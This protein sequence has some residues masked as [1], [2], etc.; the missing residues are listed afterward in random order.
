MACDCSQDHLETSGSGVVWLGRR[1]LLYFFCMDPSSYLPILHHLL[2]L[3]GLPVFESVFLKFVM[4]F[5][6]ETTLRH[7]SRDEGCKNQGPLA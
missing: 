6:S 4:E 2:S 1:C 7:S 5:N 3:C